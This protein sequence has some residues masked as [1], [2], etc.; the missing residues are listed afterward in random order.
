[1]EPIHRIEP[2]LPEIRPV[3]RVE[4]RPI[5]REERERRQ[6]ER[7]LARQRAR[8][9]ADGAAPEGPQEGEDGRPHVDLTA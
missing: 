4:P 9:Q 3:A 2:R 1:M 8:R 7:E 6:R 5:T